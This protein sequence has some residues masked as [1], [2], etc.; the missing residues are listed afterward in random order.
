MGSADRDIDRIERIA[1]F[2]YFSINKC[3]IFLTG[4]G[5]P[6]FNPLQEV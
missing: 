1:K 2:V 3:A 5:H 6:H 4:R